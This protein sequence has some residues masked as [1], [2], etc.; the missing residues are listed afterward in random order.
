[1]RMEKN[2]IEWNGVKWNGLNL[3]LNFKLWFKFYTDLFSVMAYVRLYIRYFVLKS[4]RKGSNC[5]QMNQFAVVID[6]NLNSP[7]ITFP[8]QN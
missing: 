2:E 3:I 5:V 6:Q 7:H 1:M 8:C 4:S